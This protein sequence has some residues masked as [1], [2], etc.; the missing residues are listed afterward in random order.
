MKGQSV[1]TDEEQVPTL[2]PFIQSGDLLSIVEKLNI[3]EESSTLHNN[4]M[5][6][7]STAPNIV[8]LEEKVTS[9]LLL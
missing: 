6:I 7:L 9:C 5:E 4:I 8:A 2:P 3:L 1:Q